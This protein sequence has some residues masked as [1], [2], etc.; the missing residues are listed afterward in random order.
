MILPFTEENA[1]EVRDRGAGITAPYKTSKLLA[2]INIA[3][4]LGNDT[5]KQMK[6]ELGIYIYTFLKSRPAKLVEAI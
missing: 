5:V 3:Y 2:W 6:F 4:H 1:T